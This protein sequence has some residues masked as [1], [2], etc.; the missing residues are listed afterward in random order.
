MIPVPAWLQNLIG[1]QVNMMVVAGAAGGVL[2]AILGGGFFW[3]RKRKKKKLKAS[4]T[5]DG[6]PMISPTE[7]RMGAPI[8]SSFTLVPLVSA[9]MC[10]SAS[11]PPSAV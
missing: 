3:W 1:K 4:A 8:S 5:V 10:N 7:P 9:T 6:K 2:L 11:Q